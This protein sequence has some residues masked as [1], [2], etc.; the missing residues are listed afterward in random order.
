M[1]KE[2][3]ERC[4]ELV[5]E[6]LSDLTETVNITT[7]SLADV[8]RHAFSEGVKSVTEEGLECPHCDRTF[9]P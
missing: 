4:D 9:I 5:R 6:K 1:N 2:Q 8:L 3:E 7:S